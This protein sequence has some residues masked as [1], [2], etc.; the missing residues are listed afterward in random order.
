MGCYA[1]AQTI[2]ATANEA[3]SGISSFSIPVWYEGTWP[4]NA[5]WASANSYNVTMASEG[6]WIPHIVVT[7]AAGNASASSRPSTDA[8]QLTVWD[9]DTTAGTLGLNFNGYTPGTWTSGN[10]TI[11]ISGY[12]SGCNQ[13]KNYYY[14]IN[15][16]GW[17]YLSTGNSA[18]YSVTTDAYYNIKFLIT[19]GWGRWGQQTGNYLIAK[20]TYK[21]PENYA[22]PSP[23]ES[24][25]YFFE[26][27]NPNNY[28]WF[29]NELWRIVSKEAD[30]TYK[31]ILNGNIG[32]MRW[33]PSKTDMGYWN[34]STELQIYLNGTYYNGLS[35]TA[36]A[37]IQ[38]KNW[39]AGMYAGG[40]STN[41]TI[42]AALF[43]GDKATQWAGNVALIQATDYMITGTDPAC[44]N[45]STTCASPYNCQINNWLFTGYRYHVLNS[46]STTRN[47]TINSTGSISLY[48]P[49]EPYY[50]RPTVH[51]KA[52]VRF[53]GSGTSSDPYVIATY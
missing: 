52:S 46:Y 30:G 32:S 5:A 27:A 28:V 9:I 25:E 31:I 42:Y 48:L 17:I 1:G 12:N 38:Y 18:T 14:S 40:E 23:Y 37:Q 50:V 41:M 36:K 2:T 51:L 15:D 13:T 3:Q 24:G 4:N 47:R 43:G 11:T 34:A 10:V 49:Y 8:N 7:D 20:N 6:R 33:N 16:G 39:D 29:N 45:Y 53:T 26:G 21:Y 22:S 19:D 35:A 44:E